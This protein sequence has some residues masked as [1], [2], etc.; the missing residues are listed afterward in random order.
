V[1]LV[2]IHLFA[3][4]GA[5]L[6]VLTLGA[7]AAAADPTFGV[8]NASG[9]IYWRSGPD[10][11]TAEAVA[12]NGFYPGTIIAVHC[13]ESGAANVPGSTDS[14][15][16]QASWTSGPGSGSGWIN[17]HFINDGSA[18]N[19]P[20]PGVPAC[21]SGGGSG[22][23][24]PGQFDVMNASGGI[25]WRSGPDWNTAEAVAGNGFYPG[26]V[27]AVS[28]YQSGAA[29][30]PGSTDGMWENA[31]W[32]S[33]PGSG[34][35]WINEHFID[36]G[37]AINQP[38]PGVPPCSTGGGGT[39]SGGG[40]GTGGGSGGG[41]G[42]GGGGL[43]AGE[44]NVMN[45]DGGV[46]WRSG[47]NWNTADAVSGNGFYPGTVVAV[48][49]YQ[50]GAANV[51]GSTD[52][53]WE[54]ASYVSGPGSGSGWINEH[55]INDGAAINHSSPGVPPCSGNGSPAHG[56]TLPTSRGSSPS[57]SEQL[58]PP[59]PEM[60]CATYGRVRAFGIQITEG[61]WTVFPKVGE[62]LR[63]TP[64]KNNWQCVYT[65]FMTTG[66][67]TKEG[68]DTF[69][70]P[71]P[72]TRTWPVDFASACQTQFPGTT[73]RWDS[74]RRYPWVCVGQA[75]RYYPPPN[76]TRKYLESHGGFVSDGIGAPSSGTIAVALDAPAAYAA[77]ASSRANRHSKIVR[78]AAGSRFVSRSGHYAVRIKLTPAGRQLLRQARDIA[79]SVTVRF[80]PQGHHGSRRSLSASFVLRV[81]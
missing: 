17:E 15:W 77:A 18:I 5:F 30:V 64:G 44:F 7:S 52:S 38:S 78:I 65:V 68:T 39:G 71:L 53:M 34:S 54:E 16:E 67:T 42:A 13:Y 29:N 66:G 20:S 21:G 43:S 6:G 59:D 41:A 48:Y 26:T 23:L 49:C 47:P 37:A 56:T 25:Y 14:M 70:F 61:G 60:W 28:C 74:S 72:V 3:L 55:F 27:I 12:G 22:G 69:T 75:G 31:S 35:G 81:S 50:L 33:G 63:G 4:I 11:N 80:T 51:P 40:G 1:V 9:G 58:L 2:R 8:M 36:D 19:Q 57:P 62:P 10:W 76:T 24:P 32:V 73:L 79:V 46:Y 45:A